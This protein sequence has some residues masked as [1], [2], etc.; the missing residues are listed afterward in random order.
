MASLQFP[1]LLSALVRRVKTRRGSEPGTYG[2]C[3][4]S[5]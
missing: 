2:E 3:A 1:E 4:N 5:L